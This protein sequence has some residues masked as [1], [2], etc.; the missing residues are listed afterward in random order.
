[1]EVDELYRVQGVPDTYAIGDNALI[2]DRSTGQPFVQNGQAASKQG[3]LVVD[4]LTADLAGEQVSPKD[5][6]LSGV[7]ISLGPYL[8][9][10]TLYQPCKVN[11][12]ISIFSRKLKKIV[13]WRYKTMDIR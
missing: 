9:T 10:G 1:L 5:I 7:L 13:E 6:E 12:P 8:G 4:Y 3:E 11:L 2:Y